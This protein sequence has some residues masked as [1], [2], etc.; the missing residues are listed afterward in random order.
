[1]KVYNLPSYL[2]YLCETAR[3]VLAS[4]ETQNGS[5]HNKFT[6]RFSV[7]VPKEDHHDKI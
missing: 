2:G 5:V 7:S 4:P 1:M 6:Y 3:M